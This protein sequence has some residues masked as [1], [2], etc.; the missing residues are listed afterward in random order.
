[1]T[2][3]SYGGD[4]IPSKTFLNLPEEKKQ[5]IID[6]IVDEF[7]QNDF[8]N[9]KIS[10]IVRK[11]GIPRGSI[12]QYFEDKEDIYIYLIDIIRQSKMTYLQDLLSNPEDMPLFDLFRK[13]Y[14]AGLNFSLENPKYIRVFSYLMNSRGKLY[15]S[16][17][18]SNLE[19]A[20]QFYVSMVEKDKQKGLIRED[21]DS[22]VLSKIII[23]LTSNV[24]I[25]EIQIG[26]EKLNYDKMLERITQIIEIIEQGVKKR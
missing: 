26:S 1:M 5:R 15:D 16:V 25:E 21:V 9:A 3:V 19:Y 20:Y 23:D 22:L 6:C 7:S 2:T 14:V 13:L 8:D 24:S 12:Y 17:F 10:N 18:K 4:T 11:A